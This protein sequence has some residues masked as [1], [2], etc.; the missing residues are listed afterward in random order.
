MEEVVAMP[1]NGYRGGAENTESRKREGGKKGRLA[2]ISAPWLLG[3][4]VILTPTQNTQSAL[5][6]T[7]LRTDQEWSSENSHAMCHTAWVQQVCALL[8]DPCVITCN[9]QLI[10]ES[11]PGSCHMDFFSLH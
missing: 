7:D 9:D 3:L 2:P 11:D 5:A 6:V 10:G 8:P 1:A 4:G